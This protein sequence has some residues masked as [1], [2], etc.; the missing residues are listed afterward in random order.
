MGPKAKFWIKVA[1]GFCAL[2][3]GSAFGHRIGLEGVWVFVPA[4]AAAMAV[5][6][7]VWPNIIQGEAVSQKERRDAL[8]GTLWAAGA[9]FVCALLMSWAFDSLREK[10]ETRSSQ[11]RLTPSTDAD[12]WPAREQ[13]GR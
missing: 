4:F 7:L 3:A 10:R 6:V 8:V 11:E 12:N 1:L 5:Q 9:F 13:S 2:L